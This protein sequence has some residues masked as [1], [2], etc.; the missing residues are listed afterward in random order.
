MTAGVILG[1]I[2]TLGIS[3]MVIS[4][5][6]SRASAH[7]RR[8]IEGASFAIGI[9]LLLLAVA[10]ILSELG[11]FEVGDSPLPDSRGWLDQ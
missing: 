10:I 6:I 4:A 8:E 3:L 2:V 5:F 9:T 11:A 7:A 1:T